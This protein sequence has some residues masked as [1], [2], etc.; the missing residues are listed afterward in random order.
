MDGRNQY[1]PALGFGALT[2]FYDPVVALTT[3]E[4]LFRQRLLDQSAPASG[5][6]ILDLGCGTGTLALLFARSQPGCEVHGLDPDPEMLARA[7][8]KVEQGGGSGIV[9][10]EG[11]SNDLP[12]EDGY[13]D[14]VVSTLLFHHLTL[15][16]KRETAKEIARVL[17]PG[18][19]LHI[20]D[21][22]RPSDP[23]MW[24]LSRTVRLFDG[25]ESTRDSLAGRLP[26]ILDQAGFAEARPTDRLRTVF[27][28]LALYEARRPPGI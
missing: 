21:W 20:A 7:R 6:R 11:F 5:E 1:V 25:F 10:T 22:G 3:R 19:R 23:A 13:F 9:F 24:V 16:V 17:R 2:R 18:G 4:K 28:T 14:Q 12:Y 26:E 8:A 15:G 27:G